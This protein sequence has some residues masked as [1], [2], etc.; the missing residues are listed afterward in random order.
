MLPS[1][2]LFRYEDLLKEALKPGEFAETLHIFA[3][4]ASLGIG[5]RMYCPPAGLAAEMISEPLTRTV[6]GRGV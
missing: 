2:F 4:S 3:V 5:F 1:F 6:Y